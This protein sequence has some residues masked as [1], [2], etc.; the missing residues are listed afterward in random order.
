MSMEKLFKLQKT[1]KK[2][3]RRANVKKGENLLI[4]ANTVTNRIIIDVIFNAAAKIGASPLTIT[5]P[6]IEQK[7]GFVEPPKV[8][9]TAMKTADV[10]IPLIPWN[11]LSPYT[12]AYLE[13]LK[14]SRVLG[15]QMLSVDNI[16]NW[17]LNID[18]DKIDKISQVLT[19]LLSDTQEF[20]I[21]STGGTD[22]TM[23]FGNRHI[24]D[25]PGKVEKIGEEN[26]LPGA[27]MCV[28]PLE[29][30]WEGTI[31]FDG[32]VYPPIGLLTSPI[33]LEVSEGIVKNI[34]GMDDAK[35]FKKWLEDFNDPN[36][37]RMCH[38]GIGMN[39]QLNKF[40]GI[41]FWDERIFGIVGTGLGTNDIP[42]FGGKI[43]AK[44]HTDGYMRCASVYIDGV[45][46]IKKGRFV[47]PKLKDLSNAHFCERTIS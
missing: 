27:C 38:I 23:T 13:M 20:K 47:H 32:L 12:N 41:K 9:A 30:S 15:I 31:V 37:F 26:Y 16:I 25:D 3:V 46:L 45:P 2:I 21:D 14:H 42:V 5:V 34:E 40:S 35:R 24:A 44:G 36:M 7:D 43:R 19:D 6:A 18:Y 22:I 11:Q 17:I 1:G 33:K 29:E 28:A 8:L 4:I 39:P 10:V